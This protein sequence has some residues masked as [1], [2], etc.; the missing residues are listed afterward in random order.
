VR[1][2]NNQLGALLTMLAGT[3]VAILVSWTVTSQ[4]HDAWW[5]WPAMGASIA[6]MLVGVPLWV[7]RQYQPKSGSVAQRIRRG[8]YTTSD[9]DFYDGFDTAV[10]NEGEY[11]SSGS[12]YRAPRDE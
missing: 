7:R 4:V 10:I 6:L 1:V 9:R 2:D 12:L 11:H 3:A 5:W 8:G